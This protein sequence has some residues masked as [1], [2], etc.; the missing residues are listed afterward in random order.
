MSTT[1]QTTHVNNL[2]YL[3]SIIPRSS[4]SENAAPAG[5]SLEPLLDVANE[6]LP[7]FNKPKHLD[8][9]WP[10]I[11]THCLLVTATLS[12]MIYLFLKILFCSSFLEGLSPFLASL[13]PVLASLY[14]LCFLLLS[15]SSA[16]ISLPTSFSRST[17]T[18]FLV[19]LSLF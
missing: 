8:D 18:L 15:R 3:S 19:A 5:A 10:A 13:A 6:R 4:S 11:Y 16:L 14:F 2:T 12:S 7:L 1:Q 17:V 9:R